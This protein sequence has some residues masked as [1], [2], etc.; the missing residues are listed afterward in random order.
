MTT[1]PNTRSL[2]KSVSLREFTFQFKFIPLSE[3]EHDHV[4]SIIK[5]FRTELYPEDITVDVGG[6]PDGG[7][8]WL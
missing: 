6:V 7:F 5:F 2:F 8:S 3:Q 1:N 4:I